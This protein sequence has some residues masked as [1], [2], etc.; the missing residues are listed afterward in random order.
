[1]GLTVQQGL[2]ALLGG[3]Q[4]S[5]PFV[6]GDQ[7][8]QTTKLKSDL[9]EQEQQRSLDRAKGLRQY[10][11][12]DAG[13]TVGHVRIDPRQLPNNGLPVLTPA[14]ETAEKSAGKDYADYEAAGGRAN[15][16]KNLSLLEG[17][18]ADLAGS[19]RGPL[20]RAA[21]ILPKS[22][23]EFLTPKEVAV[24]DKVKSAVQATLRQTLGAQFTEKEGQALMD[25]AYNPRL[26]TEE[27]LARVTAT[28]NELAQK[29]AQMDQSGDA[30]RR[31]GYATVGV[32]PVKSAKAP[33]NPPT[34]LSPAEQAE[35]DQLRK[36]MGR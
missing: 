5:N 14:Q 25:R 7:A 27:N 2:Q 11:G 3:M 31:T 12:K 30:Y 17:A 13:I 24:E 29:K 36:E 32:K 26:S 1:M 34:G 23:R 19:D 10:L 4:G 28:A 9:A 33:K 6:E 18:K 15:I 8:R 35:L 20:T 16:D 22:L 21:G